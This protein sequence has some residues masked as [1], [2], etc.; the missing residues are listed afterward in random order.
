MWKRL[1]LF[2]ACW[3]TVLASW[4]I[5]IV[6]A[7][8]LA[9]EYIIMGGADLITWLFWLHVIVGSLVSYKYLWPYYSRNLKLPIED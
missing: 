4:I 6:V 9:G 5:S 1:Q 7:I 8:L 2:M 3:A